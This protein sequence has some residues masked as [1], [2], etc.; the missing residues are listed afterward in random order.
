MADE[1]G[2]LEMV[3]RDGRGN[4]SPGDCL[5]KLFA[6]GQTCGPV[7]L[8]LQM[9]LQMKLRFRVILRSA[10]VVILA[11]LVSG[12]L[13]EQVERGKDRKRIPQIGKSF[14][15]GGRTLNIFCK[16]TGGPAV[17]LESGGA[18]PGLAWA[19]FQKEISKFTEVCWYDRAG[20]GWSDAG[21]YPRTSVEISK[22]LHALLQ[23][24]GVP[25]VL[26]G[27]SFGGVNSRVYA[28]LYP[29]EVAGLVL[30]DSGDEDEGRLAPKF[31]LARTAPRFL[32]HPLH[33]AFQTAGFVG[34]IRLMNPPPKPKNPAEMTDE[35]IIAAL[36]HQP[37]SIA[38]NVCT[39]IVL[40][41][42]YREASSVKSLGNIP[43]IVLAAGKPG[44]FGDAELNR[45]AAI[46]QKVWTQEIQAKL[47]RLSTRGREV[48]LE[49]SSH[50]MEVRVVIPAIREVVEEIRS[51]KANR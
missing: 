7:G 37:K 50:H 42:S 18:G 3:S 40:P 47:A 21:P 36:V 9:K 24:A 49:N 46:Y 44:D 33:V 34:L 35:E 23:R 20:E 5:W 2:R 12:I 41:E 6:M 13:Y 32:W 8:K 38:M 4:R 29:N 17:I 31:Y 27:A 14:D 26:A 51:E 15:I 45:Q 30:I 48:I 22:D 1:E 43:L 19:P 28:G 16:G 39:G 10:A 25:Y 11:L